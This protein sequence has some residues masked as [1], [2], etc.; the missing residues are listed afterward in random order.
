MSK[1]GWECSLFWLLISF[2]GPKVRPRWQAK[3]QTFLSDQMNPTHQISGTSTPKSPLYRAGTK[4][5]PLLTSCACHVKLWR[6]AIWGCEGGVTSTRRAWPATGDFLSHGGSR[7][8]FYQ[9]A[10]C[11]TD[12]W[13]TLRKKISALPAENN[14]P[15]SPSQTGSYDHYIRGKLN[16]FLSLFLAWERENNGCLALFLPSLLPVICAFP[17]LCC[18]AINS[19][20]KRDKGQQKEE[21]TSTAMA[22]TISAASMHRVSCLTSFTSKSSTEKHCGCAS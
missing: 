13:V 16:F 12:S 20:S 8:S 3:M 4:M 9:A 10:Q 14:S 19:T 17:S 22:E 7:C 6:E 1:L 11:G 18:K 15:F 2:H 5:F 21:T